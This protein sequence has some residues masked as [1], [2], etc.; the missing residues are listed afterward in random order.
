MSSVSFEGLY[1]ADGT[2]WKSTVI[3]PC[4]SC[5]KPQSNFH[6]SLLSGGI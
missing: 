3:L 4:P 1:L 5:L 6:A 2:L